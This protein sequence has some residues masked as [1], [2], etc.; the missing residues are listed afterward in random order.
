[1]LSS[2]AEVLAQQAVAAQ[3]EYDLSPE[4]QLAQALTRWLLGQ[5]VLTEAMEVTL[6]LLL[7][8]QAEVE[9][10][11]P[12]QT[13][14]RTGLLA[15]RVVAE[16]HTMG[17]GAG[18]SGISGQ[19][20]DG[21]WGWDGHPF[22]NGAGGGAGGSPSSRCVG[23][24]GVDVSSL[25]GVGV[26]DFGWVGGGGAGSENQGGTL[27]SGGQGGGG[28]GRD[29]SG[30]AGINGTGG[31]GGGSGDSGIYNAG[32]SGIVIIRYALATAVRN[33]YIG[34]TPVTDLY[35]GS[36]PINELYLGSTLIWSRGPV[37]TD[38]NLVAGTDTILAGSDTIFVSNA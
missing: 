28:Q 12:F 14:K 32:G 17:M 31:G 36:T 19:G 6:H 8:R 38:L 27:Y 10:E 3:E 9:V 25:F 7:R 15:V 1:M 2:L 26:G 21:A 5:A 23:G 4:V 37:Q 34:S 29:N 24:V 35:I 18:G 20:S 33:L 30:T 16:L 22:F 11:K 13:P